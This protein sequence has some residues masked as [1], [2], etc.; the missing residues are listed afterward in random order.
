MKSFNRT[1]G[2]NNKRFPKMTEEEFASIRSCKMR[3]FSRLTTLEPARRLAKDRLLAPDNPGAGAEDK[4]AGDDFE[5]LRASIRTIGA[6][7]K[8]LGKLPKNS[9]ERRRLEDEIGM[10]ACQLQELFVLLTTEWSEWELARQ[11]CAEHNLGLVHWVARKY[12]KGVK[13]KG[14]EQQDVINSGVSG[15]MTAIDRFNPTAKT[16]FSTYATHWI[17]QRVQLYLEDA[18]FIRL[19]AMKR[20]ILNQKAARENELFMTTGRRATVEDFLDYCS[21]EDANDSESTKEVKNRLAK[22]AV[23]RDGFLSALQTQFSPDS[24]DA[25]GSRSC[26]DGEDEET[27]GASSEPD[28]AVCD[29][30]ELASKAEDADFLLKALLKLNEKSRLIVILK[31]GSSY[32]LEA[33]HLTAFIDD[34]CSQNKKTTKLLQDLFGKNEP[35][36]FDAVGRLFGVTRQRANQLMVEALSK[37][38]SN[39][40]SGMTI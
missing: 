32:S 18:N 36:S 9:L 14:Y 11:L 25:R 4:E 35:F 21:Q 23:A 17:R 28:R 1:T 5:A 20:R 16:S 30:S 8:E 10:T 40:P 31:Y 27:S 22:S 7:V 12:G 29:P 24:L 26:E 19:P 6:L 13:E 2:D 39:L 3:L 15:L 38:K 33:L 34:L 37:M